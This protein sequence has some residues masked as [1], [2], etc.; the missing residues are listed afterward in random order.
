MKL[1]QIRSWEDLE[2]LPEDQWVEVEEGMD[3]KFI[4]RTSR[5]AGAHV[6][7]PLKPAV[8]R[9]LAPSKGEVLEATVRGNRLILVRRK[10]KSRP[11]GS[12]PT[13]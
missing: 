13:R 7:I 11:S 4:D 5:G 9:S 6:E 1:R 2:A 8:A 10:A 12:R 3:V